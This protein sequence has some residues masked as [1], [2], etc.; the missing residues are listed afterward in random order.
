[1]AQDVTP[2]RNSS[3]L[4]RLFLAVIALV[5]L[6]WAGR[7]IWTALQPPPLL[8]TDVE[9]AIDPSFLAEEDLER[10]LDTYEARI[11]QTSTPS[12]YLNLGFLYLEQ[13]RL[14]SDPAAY[15]AAATSFAIAADLSPQDPTAIL[16]QAR[17]ALATHDFAR[18]EEL[19]A[20]VLEQ[21]PTRLDALAIVADA[22]MAVGDLQGARDAIELL[23]SGLDDSPAVFVRQAEFA[24][25]TGDLTGALN[26]AV[27][28]VPT[29]ENNPRRL[30]WYEAYAGTTAWRTGRLPDAE[31]WASTA[32]DHDPGSLPALGLAAR[33]A[34]ANGQLLQAVELYEQAIAGVPDPELVGELG[35]VYN[36][37][38]RSMEA[39]LQWE[40]VKLIDTLAEAE[41]LYDRS[42]ARFYADHNLETGRAMALAQAEIEDRRDPLAYDTL[43]WTLYRAGRFEDALAAVESA[44]AS[45]FTS[46]EVSFHHGLIL[47]G[48]GREVDGKVLLEEALAFNPAFDLLG[49][50]TARRIL[51]D[52]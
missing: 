48:L 4:P 46:A 14:N 34:V 2:K 24:Y 40:L 37:L 3:L 9:A 50:E 51:G 18:A 13:A 30:A 29:D 11:T 35:D 33:L 47:I 43:A 23:A 41:G 31:K 28:A 39:K 5:A 8:A 12:D 52:Y 15:A 38:K 6:A 20:G 17:A 44:Q 42:I 32:L 10:L 36:H 22:R 1:M 21:I 45:G 25:L 27:D 19:A 26:L 16:G 49:A 7:A